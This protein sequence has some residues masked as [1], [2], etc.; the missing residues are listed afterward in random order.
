MNNIL[1]KAKVIFH[2]TCILASLDKRFKDIQHR[3]EEGRTKDY[4][5]GEYDGITFALIELRRL[6]MEIEHLKK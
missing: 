6:K 4:S 5:K 2:I 3:L 1:K